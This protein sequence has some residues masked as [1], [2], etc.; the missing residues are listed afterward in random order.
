[1]CLAVS[2]CMSRCQSIKGE[3]RT[4]RVINVAG[5]WENTDLLFTFPTLEKQRVTPESV[6]RLQGRLRLCHCR[7]LTLNLLHYADST[8]SRFLVL[9]ALVVCVH[10]L[11]VC[12]CIRAA[13][14]MAGQVLD[15]IC[16]WQGEGQCSELMPSQLP[17]CRATALFIA[18][19]PQKGKRSFP[20]SLSVCLSVF[21]VFFGVFYFLNVLIPHLEGE[22]RLSPQL[23]WQPLFASE[24]VHLKGPMKCATTCLGI[25]LHLA[26][27]ANMGIWE[28]WGESSLMVMGKG[29]REVGG[30]V[31]L[32][33]FVFTILFVSVILTHLPNKRHYLRNSIL[34][35]CTLYECIV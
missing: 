28:M 6:S 2:S 11:Y 30:V 18:L 1:M 22:L 12:V 25:V 20:P 23:L 32:K 19:T 26:S 21:I 13:G 7:F 10:V 35:K 3:T 31:K 5:V 29:R 34:S 33:Y 14:G 8:D 24:K 27:T 4:E 17:P 15:L 16:V 9:S